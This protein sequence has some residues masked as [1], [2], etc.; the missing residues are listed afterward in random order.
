MG[1][2]EPLITRRATLGAAALVPWVLASCRPS[3]PN[4]TG[5]FVG[6]H[7]ER[8]HLLRLSPV[9][10]T[11][12]TPPQ[13]IQ[14]T[15]VLIA[16]AGV[17]GLA[18][19]R[20]LRLSGMNDF[21]VL[22]L[23]DQA[24]GNARSTQL[25][26]MPCPIGAHYLPVPGQQAH[27]VQDLLEELGVR[28]RVAGRWH[29]DERHLCHSPQERLYL[30]GAWQE[31]LLPL[32][33]IG[34][35]TLHQYQL[36]AK[37]VQRL[38]Q[39]STWSLPASRSHFDAV[40][41]PLLHQSFARYLGAMGLNEPYL[42]WYLDYCC[43]DDF[44]AG[45]ATVSAWAGLHYFASRHGF[46]APQSLGGAPAAALDD[47]DQEGILTW[48]EGNAWLTQ[49]MAQPL[50]ERLH[51]GQ[52]I[53]RIRQGKHGAE[54]WSTSAKDGRVTQWQAQQ[55]VVA[56][57]VFVAARVIENPSPLLQTAAQHLRYAP[58]MVS[59]L[60]L[61][62][63]LFPGEGAAPSWDNVIFQSK[64]LGYVIATHQNLAPVPQA[65]VLT[66]Y[67]ALGDDAPQARAQL[68]G[69]SWDA[70]KAQVVAELA[71]VH[72]DL[73]YKLQE[74]QITRYGHAMTT[75]SP[76]NFGVWTWATSADKGHSTS[77]KA[78]VP[79]QDGRLHFAHSDW[80]GYSVFEEAF[81]MGDGVG[82]HMRLS[83]T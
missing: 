7:P 27:E 83:T 65:T 23:E 6:T 81:A 75:P 37:E 12:S 31:G 19:A 11:P 46:R 45:L 63:P 72:P 39:A 70:L 4:V 53:T 3:P 54:V 71:T 16:G 20:A 48:P 51:T 9:A 58:W 29:Y 2:G 59:N 43:R 69:G 34:P 21:V 79:P 18:A 32:A 57:P 82:R 76:G 14:R 78:M 64:G 56:L 62:S 68:L 80:A 50:G 28:Q 67:L 17:A 35:S 49:R 30:H 60:Q 42:L 47:S 10:A 24:G 22:D 66:H 26:G 15:R 40:Q 5:G 44:G 52:I 55:V 13:R 77:G 1:Q 38:R 8:G 61:S 36:F 41:T 74:V 25:A 73:P 33:G